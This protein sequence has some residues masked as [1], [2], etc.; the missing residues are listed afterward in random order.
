MNHA[1]YFIREYNRCSETLL[2]N[3][4]KKEN[5]NILDFVAEKNLQ[6]Y[7]MGSHIIYFDVKDGLFAKR[8]CDT[9][10]HFVGK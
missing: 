7:K 10:W 4:E 2:Q 6:Q 8:D 5:K 3:T 9:E 1:M